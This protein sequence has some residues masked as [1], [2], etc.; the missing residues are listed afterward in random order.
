MVADT[1]TAGTE[2]SHRFTETVMVVIKIS[3]EIAIEFADSL[4]RASDRAEK[5]FVARRQ[6][7]DEI[8]CIRLDAL[9]AI[10]RDAIDA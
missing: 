7:R 5:E 8:D 2:P 10:L 9:E 3:K 4:K 1:R 6:E